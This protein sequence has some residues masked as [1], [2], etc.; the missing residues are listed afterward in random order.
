MTDQEFKRLKRP[1]LL[2]ILLAQSREI[3][4]LREK[5]QQL[6]RQLESRRIELSR[7]GSIARAALELNG[8]FEK[9]QAAADM[10]LENVRQNAQQSAKAQ[11]PEQK[12]QEAAKQ[13]EPVQQEAAQQA[14]PAQQEAAKRQEAFGSAAAEGDA[15]ETQSV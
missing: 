4:A 1:E 12:T 8:I 9:A 13:A 6:T 10:Y 14:E 11:Q 7:A 2:E 5:N 3:D 15:H